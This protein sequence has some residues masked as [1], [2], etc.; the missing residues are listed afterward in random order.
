M[1]NCPLPVW[2]TFWTSWLLLSYLYNYHFGE[3]D[4]PNKS[5]NTHFAAASPQMTQSQLVT[6]LEGAYRFSIVLCISTTIFNHSLPKIGLHWLTHIELGLWMPSVLNIH[7]KAAFL[8]NRNLCKLLTNKTPQLKL[9]FPKTSRPKISSSIIFVHRCAFA[10]AAGAGGAGAAIGTA[11]SGIGAVGGSAAGA[12]GGSVC[13][14]TSATLDGP[15]EFLD[16]KKLG[17]LQVG[18]WR[19]RETNLLVGKF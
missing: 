14:A 3:Q 1:K 11:V 2:D 18:S 5:P 8:G 6:H 17:K 12:A 13:V 19:W 16:G 4:L 15:T 7:S 9:C 10:G